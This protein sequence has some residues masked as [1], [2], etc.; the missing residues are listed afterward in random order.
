VEE[1]CA[2]DVDRVSGN[3]PFPSRH[4][5]DGAESS[6]KGFRV[7]WEA[8]SGRYKIPWVSAKGGI[9]SINRWI[10]G[11]AQLRNCC[12]RQDE[13]LMST[14]RLTELLNLRPVYTMVQWY[15]RKTFR[16]ASQVRSRAQAQ[17]IGSKQGGYDPGSKDLWYR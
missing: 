7:P 13:D 11:F 10:R 16:N 9:D 8:V 1:C 2:V 4:G 17:C 12:G 5:G 14:T 6:N 15:L 3:A